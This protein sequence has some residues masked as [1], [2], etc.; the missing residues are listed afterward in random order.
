MYKL[1]KDEYNNLLDNAVTATYKKATKGIED[2][3]NK[4]G[5]KYE[6]RADIFD[7]IEINGASNCFITFKDQRE[8]FVNHPKTRLIDPAKNKI[9]RISKSILDNINICL[10]EKLKLSEWKNTT[11]V[12]NWF[13]K[14]DEK[15]LDTLTIC[16]INDF[17]PSIKGTLLKNAVQL[18]AEHT[19]IN[20]NDFEVIF[21]ARK[22]LL[23]YSN[24]PWIKTDSDTFE[25]RMGA[26]DGAEICKLGG[27]FMLSLLSKK[28]SSNNV[29]LHRDDGLSGF[30]NVSRQQAEKQKNNPKNFQ[31]S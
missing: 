16:D 1:T 30:R 17:Y 4:E 7:R 24:Q 15:R 3:I 9:G 20:K 10:C 18:A 28:Y 31:N 5:I 2:I 25:V 27:I 11:D 12:I 13:E 19:D 26:Y 21:H 23:F 14:I 22:S 6:K 29:G 8:N